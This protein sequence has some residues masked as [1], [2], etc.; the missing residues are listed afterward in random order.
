MNTR[1]THPPLSVDTRETT[2]PGLVV[3]LEAPL[4]LAPVDLQAVRLLLGL[5]RQ[6]GTS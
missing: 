2:E 4:R 3:D 6:T 5:T 1:L